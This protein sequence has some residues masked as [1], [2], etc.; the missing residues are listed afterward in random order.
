MAIIHCLSHLIFI[1]IFICICEFVSFFGCILFSYFSKQYVQSLENQEKSQGR[2]VRALSCS[3]EKKK[4]KCH[5]KPLT[6]SGCRRG[7]KSLTFQKTVSH[8]LTPVHH[9]Q[10]EQTY[11]NPLR[12]RFENCTH[13]FSLLW[14]TVSID[15]SDILSV[16]LA[17]MKL[18]SV[19]KH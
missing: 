13:L 10:I 7:G 5:T 2:K 8:F 3:V 18:L 17:I 16:C 1:L 6:S 11:T 12:P 19:E 9:S 14:C 15:T 4:K